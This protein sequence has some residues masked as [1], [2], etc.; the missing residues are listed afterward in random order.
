M[1]SQA[2]LARALGVAQQ[3]VNNWLRRGKV[4]ADYCPLIERATGRRVVCEEIRPDVD[5]PF[6]RDNDPRV[7]ADSPTSEPVATVER[8]AAATRRA[9]DRRADVLDTG[10]RR[11]GWRRGHEIITAAQALQQQLELNEKEGA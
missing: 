2:A 10:G 1:G 5:W 4:P 7:S 11:T 3:V 8:S 9:S 6:L